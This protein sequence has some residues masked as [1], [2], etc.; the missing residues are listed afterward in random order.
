PRQPRVR[1][2]RAV[3]S[4]PDRTASPPHGG[5]G[6]R[7]PARSADA[8]SAARYPRPA[9]NSPTPPVRS[10]MLHRFAA[11]PLLLLLGAACAPAAPAADL[12]VFGK[13][14]TGDSAAPLAQAVATRGDTVVAVGDS[15]TV[16]K[17]VGEAT[18]V[19]ANPGGLVVPGFMDDH[20]HF[21]DGGFQLASVDLRDAESP[22]EFTRRLQAFAAERQPGEW[23]TGGD[24]DH[25]RW[26]GAPLPRREWIDSVT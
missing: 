25:E 20:V 6:C 2:P 13:V 1:L 10:C 19:L 11:V 23:I 24:W 9:R 4:G 14:W 12:V 17:L 3:R 26:P 18:R 5:A 8:G 7:L 15:A 21:L 22:A 16:A